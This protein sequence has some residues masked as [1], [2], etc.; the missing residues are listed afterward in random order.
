MHAGSTDA[1]L[2]SLSGLGQTLPISGEALDGYPYPGG[3]WPVTFVWRGYAAAFAGSR[4]SGCARLFAIAAL[5]LAL[6][7]IRAPS[8][9]A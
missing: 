6:S 4:L 2:C 3:P 7:L 5:V 8:Y 9:A 1:R